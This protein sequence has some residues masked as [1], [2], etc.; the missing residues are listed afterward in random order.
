MRISDAL[1]PLDHEGT[2]PEAYPINSM[3]IL[4]ARTSSY[5]DIVL[6]ECVECDAEGRLDASLER[7]YRH[8]RLAQLQLNTLHGSVV[9]IMNA[10]LGMRPMTKGN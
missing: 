5:L 10:M 2:A 8:T 4:L 6:A 9:S 3:P 7:I 1:H